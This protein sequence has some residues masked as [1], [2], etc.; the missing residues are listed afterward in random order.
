MVA[1]NDYWRVLVYEPGETLANEDPIS[2][3]PTHLSDDALLELTV[4]VLDFDIRTMALAYTRE[5]REPRFVL[6]VIRKG[7]PWRE[8]GEFDLGS[9]RLKKFST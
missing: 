6:S 2:S 8:I 3:S 7:E 4:E 1:Y 5:G 9:G